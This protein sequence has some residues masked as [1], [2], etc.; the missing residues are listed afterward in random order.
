MGKQ[1]FKFLIAINAMPR[2]EEDEQSVPCIPKKLAKWIKRH[3][4]EIGIKLLILH[5]P[6]TSPNHFFT[7]KFLEENNDK[8]EL[9]DTPNLFW[10]KLGLA[11][12]QGLFVK[13]YTE[14]SSK[15]EKWLN[16]M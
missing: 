13:F 8:V 2:D 1:K 12:G 15:Y 9:V 5:S 7:D 4:E 14:N 6:I 10:L 3:G 16:E 11:V